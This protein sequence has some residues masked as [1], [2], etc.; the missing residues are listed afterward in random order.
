[1]GQDGLGLSTDSLNN[2]NIS[3]EDLV[4]GKAE[5]RNINVRTAKHLSMS[6][7]GHCGSF[8]A[9]QRKTRDNNKPETR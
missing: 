3:K 8:A 6:L 4:G 5:A 2:K 1:M 9:T 7:V